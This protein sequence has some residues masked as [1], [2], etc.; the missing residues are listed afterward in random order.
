MAH[1][2]QTRPGSSL[3]PQEEAPKLFSLGSEA[4]RVASSGEG[5]EGQG[6]TVR[7]ESSAFRQTT[8]PHPPR[9]PART[10]AND[11]MLGSLF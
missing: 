3:G 8:F 1:A 5:V 4:V 2:E 6:D 9:L 7:C 10:N 11:V